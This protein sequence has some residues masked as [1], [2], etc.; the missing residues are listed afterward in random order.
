MRHS[1]LPS[2]RARSRGQIQVLSD[3]LSALG[4]IFWSAYNAAEMGRK[5]LREMDRVFSV[6]S[7]SSTENQRDQDT[8]TAVSRQN[9]KHSRVTR[10]F[11]D[12]VDMK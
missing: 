11:L 5:L 7:A 3:A 2:H 6:V 12:F 8:A 9:G 1:K 4:G 10:L